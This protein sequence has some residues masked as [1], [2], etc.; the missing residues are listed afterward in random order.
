M[1]V[2]STS[3]GG[4]EE[5][6]QVYVDTSRSRRNLGHRRILIIAG[7]TAAKAW[8][9]VPASDA[10]GKRRAVAIRVCR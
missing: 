2:R 7:A 5:Q 1:L 10:R 6:P 3:T 4:I 8:A 9:A